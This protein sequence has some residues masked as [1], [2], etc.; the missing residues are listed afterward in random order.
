MGEKKRPFSKIFLDFR[1]W[2]FLKM[3]KFDFGPDFFF[4]ILKIRKQEKKIKYI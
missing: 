1:F 4:E 3:S 2:T